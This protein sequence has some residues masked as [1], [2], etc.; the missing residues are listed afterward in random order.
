MESDLRRLSFG[1]SVLLS[2][3]RFLCSGH[4]RCVVR[5][6][7]GGMKMPQSQLKRKTFVAIAFG[8]AWTCLRLPSICTWPMLGILKY[9]LIH[10][11]NKADMARCSGISTDGAGTM[12]VSIRLLAGY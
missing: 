12:C 1:A 8:I 5:K 9:R 3:G 11:Q 2:L 7:K 6:T 4:P 10:S